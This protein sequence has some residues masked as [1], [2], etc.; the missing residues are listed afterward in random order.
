MAS[1]RQSRPRKEGMNM[2]VLAPALLVAF[3][4]FQAQESIAVPQSAAPRADIQLKQAAASLT[5]TSDTTW[6]LEKIGSLGASTITWQEQ[7]GRLHHC[8]RR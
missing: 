8:D 2:R 6:T 5:N 1:A 4:A 7:P 3:A